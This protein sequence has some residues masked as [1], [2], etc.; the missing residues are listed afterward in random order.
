MAEGEEECP[1]KQLDSYLE[2]IMSEGDLED[3]NPGG[4]A[5]T[6]QLEGATVP[7]DLPEERSQLPMPV[8]KQ[9]ETADTSEE[10]SSQLQIVDVWSTA[11]N[12]TMSASE[13]IDEPTSPT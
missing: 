10:T 3:A 5:R 13:G 1:L 11:S 12:S 7:E 6:D 4:A 8:A 9:L 2:V